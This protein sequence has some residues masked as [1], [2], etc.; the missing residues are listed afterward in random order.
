[1]T[2]NDFQTIFFDTYAFVEILKG[3]PAYE[4][5]K[6]NVAILTTRLNLMELHHAVLRLWNKDEANQNYDF[7][8]PFAVNIENE[9][10]KKASEL[11]FALK[12]VKGKKVSY[13]DCIGY[14]IAQEQKIPFLTG[15]EQFRHME[16]VIFVK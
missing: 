10:L 8:L 6:Q 9:I 4:P 7:F 5:Y 16:N 15:D 3:N 2:T 1:M 11:R 13:I 12:K 14:L